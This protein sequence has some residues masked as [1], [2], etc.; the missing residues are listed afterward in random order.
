M[1]SPSVHP[2]LPPYSILSPWRHKNS[3]KAE[4][5]LEVKWQFGRR[6]AKEKVPFNRRASLVSDT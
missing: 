6:G 4:R 5:Y 1:Q 2:L 3:C